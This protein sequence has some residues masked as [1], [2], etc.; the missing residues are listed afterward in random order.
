MGQAPPAGVA[1]S[2]YL[3]KAFFLEIGQNIRGAFT[4]NGNSKVWPNPKFLLKFTK[5]NFAL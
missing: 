2:P 5:T 1:P 4:K 3:T